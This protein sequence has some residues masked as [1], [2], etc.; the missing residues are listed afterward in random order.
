MLGRVWPENPVA[1]PDFLSENATKWWANEMENVS[2]RI[3]FRRFVDRYER[4]EQF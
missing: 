4:A 2:Q 3:K 1:Y